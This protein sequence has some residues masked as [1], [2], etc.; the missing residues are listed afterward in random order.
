MF[1]L[2]FFTPYQIIFIFHHFLNACLISVI[3][4]LPPT[5]KAVIL[6]E[7]YRVAV[8][9]VPVPTIKEDGDVLVKVHLAGL[10]GGSV[11]SLYPSIRSLNHR[12]PLSTKQLA[13]E[14]VLVQQ[15][16]EQGPTCTST[17]GRR[18]RRRVSPSDMSFSERWLMLG[19]G[20][21]S[22]RRAT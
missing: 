18:D 7:S 4:S 17:E 8:E 2:T 10:C 20:F 22:S 5:M 9:E 6:K 19:R 3:M 1:L 11:H 15:L 12:V 16:T 13:P 21:R 14:R